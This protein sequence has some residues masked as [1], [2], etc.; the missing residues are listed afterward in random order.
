MNQTITFTPQQ[1][2]TAVL[3][4]CGAIVSVAAAAAVVIKLFTKIKAPNQE[5][6]KK[7]AKHDEKLQEIDRTLISHGKAINDIDRI[8][9]DIDDLGKRIDRHDEFFE[10]DKKHF[11]LLDEGNRVLQQA[12][13]ALL[14]HA[15]DGNNTEPLKAAK[16]SLEQYLI[17]R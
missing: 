10:N 14:T 17:N 6:N 12:I 16:T 8:K 4:M 3:F 2:L 5:Q 15:L 1:L 13:L 11:E 7:L 9:L